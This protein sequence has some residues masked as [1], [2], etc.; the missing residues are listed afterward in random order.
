MILQE[1]PDAIGVFE[2]LL[3]GNVAQPELLEQGT[4]EALRAPPASGIHRIVKR[5]EVA[6]CRV[7]SHHH[8]ADAH[9][10]KT[11]ARYLQGARDS[12]S[13]RV[14]NDG[15]EALARPAVTT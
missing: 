5:N 6:D 3:S 1:P 2:S 13:A 14:P 4:L 7:L 12:D 9:Q 11:H 15:E 8:L 10:H